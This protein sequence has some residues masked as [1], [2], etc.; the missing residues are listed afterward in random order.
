MKRREKTTRYSIIAALFKDKIIAPFIFEGTCFR[1]LFEKYLEEILLPNVEEG[2]AF[3]FDN[4][5]FHRGGRIQGLIE[6]AG[7]KILYLPSY[8]PDFNPIEHRWDPLKKVLKRYLVEPITN[9]CK[10]AK[11]AFKEILA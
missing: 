1:E 2:L 5:S 10:W 9:I 7:C 4:A 3:I 11:K 8:S 6:A